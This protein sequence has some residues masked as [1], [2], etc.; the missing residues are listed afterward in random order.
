MDPTPSSSA[1]QVVDEV[2]LARSEVPIAG[3]TQTESTAEEEGD[4]V[5][6]KDPAVHQ[7]PKVKGAQTG[8]VVEGLGGE[9][10][11]QGEHPEEEGED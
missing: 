2:D 4:T 5:Q 6:E 7:V 10:A 8:A 9:V 11:S 1:I 3:G